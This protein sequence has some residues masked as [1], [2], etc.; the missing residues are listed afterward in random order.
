MSTCVSSDGEWS[1]HLFSDADSSQRFVCQ[2]CGVYDSDASIEA[3]CALVDAE[4][5]SSDHYRN[6][7]KWKSRALAAEAQVAKVRAMLAEVIDPDGWQPYN[8]RDIGPAFLASSVSELVDDILAALGTVAATECHPQH[9]PHPVTGR[10]VGRIERR[11]QGGSTWEP[12]P[13]VAATEAQV[14]AVEPE[15]SVADS[16]SPVGGAS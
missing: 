6:A 10:R 13:E 9:A 1:A 12:C 4:E 8:T 3:I 7:L 5:S 15:S 11:S 14:S 2:R 16:G